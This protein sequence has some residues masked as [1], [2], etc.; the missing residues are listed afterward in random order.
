MS[1]YSY[2]YSIIGGKEGIAFVYGSSEFEATIKARL[3]I[4]MFSG[5][6]NFIINNLHVA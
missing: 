4:I 6:V 3:D 5:S 1:K 2:H